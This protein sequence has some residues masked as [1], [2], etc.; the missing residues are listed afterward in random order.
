MTEENF[1]RIP[2]RVTAF[3]GLG[4]LVVNSCIKRTRKKIS[5]LHTNDVIAI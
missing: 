1:Y 4:G 3:V 5:I 2:Q